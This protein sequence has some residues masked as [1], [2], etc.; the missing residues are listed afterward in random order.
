MYDSIIFTD[1]VDIM[2]GIPPIGAYK[3]AHVLRKNGYSCLVVN[4]LSSFTL[5]EIK[6]V[7]DLSVTKQTLLVGFSTTFL[8]N[9]N[10]EK[11][12]G[13]PT[14]QLEPLPANTVFPQGKQ[15]EDEVVARLRELNPD[16]KLLAGGAKVS[17]STANKNLDYIIVGYAETSIINLMNHL[18]KGTELQNASKNIHGRIVVNDQ[19][20]KDYDFVNE[21]MVWLPE[22]VVNHKTLPLEIGRGCVFKCKFCSYPLN[23]KQQLDFVKR[24]YNLEDELKENYERYGIEQYLLLDDTFNDHEDK[25]NALERVVGRLPFQPK[26]W[27][28]HRLDLI[29]TRPHT[30]ETLH[31]IGVRGMFFGIESLNPVTAKIVGKGFSGDKQIETLHRMKEHYSDI[32]RHGSFIVGLPEDTLDYA[33]TT[34]DKLLSQDIPLES[35]KFH[36]LWIAKTSYKPYHSEIEKDYGKFGYEKIGDLGPIIAWRNSHMDSFSAKALVD[37]IMTESNASNK[38]T[39]SSQIAISIATMNHPNFTFDSIKQTKHSDF[40]WYKLET[41]VKPN[42]IQDYKN[43]LFNLIS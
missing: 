5:E 34:A 16:I 35:W 18:A 13:E 11:K 2:G 10:V 37:Q 29:A 42:F 41:E 6:K 38:M 31:N 23:G 39:V 14:P 40:N 3:C 43:Q 24:D 20:A 15:F 33:R 36:E 12:E 21:R 7:I 30:L 27:G 1:E 19:F 32:S 28:Y 4:H 17:V 8:L 22:D 9:I 25:L 26:F